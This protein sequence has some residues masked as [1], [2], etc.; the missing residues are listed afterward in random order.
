MV[1]Q[2]VGLITGPMAGGG[3][4]EYSTWRWVFYINFPF[5]A[6]G[7]AMVP[8]VIRLKAQ[9]ASLR[10]RIFRTD[11]IGASLFISSTCSF[12]IGITW[13]G[14]QYPWDSWRT[15][16]PIVLGVAGIMVTLCWERYGASQPFLRVWLFQNHAA[17]AAYSCAVLQGLLVCDLFS[18]ACSPCTHLCLTPLIDVLPSV[19]P[20]HVP[21]VGSRLRSDLIR[22]RSRSHHWWSHAD[23]HHCWGTDDKAG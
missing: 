14:T 22:C 3:F 12:L 2:A 19:L 7:L 1:A 8:F 15:V 13:G 10:E 21:A 23:I 18:L 17:M 5:C 20:A 6:I 9:R 4:A 11:W 16:M